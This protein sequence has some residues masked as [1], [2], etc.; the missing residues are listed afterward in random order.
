M[1]ETATE[2]LVLITPAD[3]VTIEL[4][5]KITG[6]TVKAVERMIESGTWVEGKEYHRSP[7]GRRLVS[8]PGYRAW[9]RNG[10]RN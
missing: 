10:R 3:D 4:F 6:F 1:N 7:N 5:A 9:V 2:D 8:L